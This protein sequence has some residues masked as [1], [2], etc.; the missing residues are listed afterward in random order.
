ME[1]MEIIFK[2]LS[3]MKR[4]EILKKLYYEESVCV[5]K[6]VEIFNIPQSK[7]SYHL[8]LLLNAELIIKTPVGKWNYYSLNEEKLSEFLTAD[9]IKKLFS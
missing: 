6:L 7:L 2:A 1:H 4:L 9:A 3:D 5:C 8:K